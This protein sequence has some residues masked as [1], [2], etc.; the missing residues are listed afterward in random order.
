MNAVAPHIVFGV[1]APGERYAGSGTREINREDQAGDKG[2]K[3]E[4][5]QIMGLGIDYGIY[6]NPCAD[7]WAK[8]TADCDL[9]GMLF[10]GAQSAIAQEKPSEFEAN[11]V[12][13]EPAI[14]GSL[15]KTAACAIGYQNRK[16]Q[17]EA[18]SAQ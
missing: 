4:A 15:K 11:R 13:Y 8:R 18:L 12:D 2:C 10:Q 9:S 5:I 6:S 16:L 7:G 1:W 14:R 17:T 3:P